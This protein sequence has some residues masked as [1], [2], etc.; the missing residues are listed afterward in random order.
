MYGAHHSLRQDG[1]VGFQAG[2]LN[3]LRGSQRGE[4]STLLSPLPFEDGTNWLYK[5]HQRKVLQRVP[6]TIDSLGAR[7]ENTKVMSVIT[8][9][10][11]A[12]IRPNGVVLITTEASPSP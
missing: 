12:L 11:Q 1:G 9:G 3:Q 5:R 6:I 4:Q 8:A 10:V 7:P 2:P